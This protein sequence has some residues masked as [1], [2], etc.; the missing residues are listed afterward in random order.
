MMRSWHNYVNLRRYSSKCRVRG[1]THL[2][3][4]NSPHGACKHAPY[5]SHP[6][7]FKTSPV[8]GI[9]A[10]L[11]ASRSRHR[12]PRDSASSYASARSSGGPAPGWRSGTLPGCDPCALWPDPAFPNGGRRRSACG[13]RNVRGGGFA[14]GCRNDTAPRHE[15]GRPAGS[16]GNSNLAR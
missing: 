6:N 9:R 16:S 4:R 7:P 8:P 10:K 3:R 2:L 12:G 11:A 5:R 1:C 14:P 15:S 13:W